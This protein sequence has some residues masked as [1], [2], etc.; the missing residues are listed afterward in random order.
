MKIE[1]LT[2]RPM[3]DMMAAGEEALNVRQMD[4]VVKREPVAEQLVNQPNV[5]IESGEKANALEGRRKFLSR[6]CMVAGVAATTS[7]PKLALAAGRSRHKVAFFKTCRFGRD[8]NSGLEVNYN[9]FTK[10]PVPGGARLDPNRDCKVLTGIGLRAHRGNVT[11]MVLV[12]S[13][14]TSRGLVKSPQWSDTV[15]RGERTGLEVF[16]YSTGLIWV[17]N[18]NRVIVGVGIREHRSNI[19]TL[20]LRTRRLNPRT[21]WLTHP[22]ELRFGR[23]PNSGLEVSG[24]TSDHP[25][26]VTNVLVSGLGFRA[27][28][29]AVTTMHLHLSKV[30]RRS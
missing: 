13:R 24:D 1:G 23:D 27:T 4:L 28:N 6:A 2:P 10:P 26:A 29:S 21:G 15:Y 14:I 30:T 18:R 8:P 3:F 11:T 12:Y 7:I 9:P 19:T 5:A 25:R 20:R 17:P 16:G 22:R